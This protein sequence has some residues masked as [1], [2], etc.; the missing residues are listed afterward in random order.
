MTFTTETLAEL[1]KPIIS[2]SELWA[3]KNL[4]VTIIANPCSGGFTQPKK[5][6]NN[7]NT[8]KSFITDKPAVCTIQNFEVIKTE[9]PGHATI[10]CKNILNQIYNDAS[11]TQ[12]LIISTGGDGTHLEVQTAI[13]KDALYYAEKAEAIKKKLAILRLPF[14]TGNDGSDGRTLDYTLRLLSE[15]AHFSLQSAVKVWFDNPQ[16]KKCSNK[17]YESL[18]SLPPWYS[19]NIASIGID[20]YVT[21]MTNKTKKLFPGDSYQMWVDLACVFYGLFFPPKP[22]HIEIFDKDDNVINEITS[23]VEFCLLGVSGHRT[24]GSD[25]KILPTDDNFCTVKK[26]SLIKK[27]LKKSSFSDG[28]HINYPFTVLGSGEKIKITYN[29]QILVQMDGEVH[30]LEPDFYPLY[31]QKTEPIVPIIEL[32]SSTVNKGAVAY[33]K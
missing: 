30:L 27:L 19:F 32:S 1:L 31:M 13:A 20:A 4:N 2:A 22:L 16:N 33:T 6:E 14:G 21:Y 15:P 11:A 7:Y 18:D 3:N 25:H 9:H 8:L 10:L 12:Y 28:S 26:L 24:Y 29:K 17:K 5:A 23:P